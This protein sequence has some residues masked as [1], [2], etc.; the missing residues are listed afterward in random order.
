MSKLIIFCNK[1]MPVLRQFNARQ[2]FFSDFFSYITT[3]FYEIGI[4]WNC[5]Q[6]L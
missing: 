5:L 6:L 3:S 1:G 4:I 2:I